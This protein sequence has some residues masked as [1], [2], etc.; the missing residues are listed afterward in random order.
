MTGTRV[1]ADIRDRHA[2]DAARSPVT[3]R[4]REVDHAG[5]ALVIFA[6]AIGIA[7][8]LIVAAVALQALR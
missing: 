6:G 4:S 5:T 7:L 8:V 1:Q 2:R 3:S